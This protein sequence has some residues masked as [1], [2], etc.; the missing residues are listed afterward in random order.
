MLSKGL[1]RGVAG[2]ATALA[3]AEIDMICRGEEGGTEVVHVCMCHVCMCQ[4][5]DGL[6]TPHKLAY[7]I[8]GRERSCSSQLL[9]GAL[10]D[11]NTLSFI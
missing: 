1:E 6:G 8:Q 3:S 7:F 2:I 11:T 10:F 5:G 9:I 4:V